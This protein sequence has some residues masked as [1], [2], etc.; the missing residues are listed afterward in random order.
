MRAVGTS[1]GVL[2]GAALL[3]FVGG[4]IGLRLGEGYEDTDP[5]AWTDM[6]LTGIAAGVLLG[7]VIGGW[8]SF[9]STEPDT[10]D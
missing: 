4:Y 8:L 6:T 9:R 1:V 7:G 10:S 5:S 3:G 2:T